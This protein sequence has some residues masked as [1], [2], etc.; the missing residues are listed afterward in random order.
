[1]LKICGRDVFVC[2]F[3]AYTTGDMPSQPKLSGSKGHQ[4]LLPCRSCNIPIEHR[5]NLEY[6]IV[7]KG[8]YHMQHLDNIAFVQGLSSKR[9]KEQAEKRLG[10]LCSGELMF[11]GIARVMLDVLFMP[12]GLLLES[13]RTELATVYQNFAFPPGWSG[14]QNPKT[15]RGSYKMNE[16]ARSSILTPVIL[17][18]WLQPCHVR[19]DL[20][21]LLVRFA[22]QFLDTYLRFPYNLAAVKGSDWI[23]AAF[24]SFALSV[25]TIFGRNVTDFSRDFARVTLHGRKAVQFLF[26]VLGEAK[27]L[28]AIR[29]D[30]QRR[31][32]DAQKFRS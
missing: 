6:D 30:E 3:I 15:H 7:K 19:A 16:H 26:H 23:I 29:S 27:R 9:A 32:T 2:S 12:D 24:W 25:L 28:A 10:V 4:A 5:A 1:N 20:H 17:R 18:C 14:L 22:P 13:A 11:A 31:K 8:R 21:E